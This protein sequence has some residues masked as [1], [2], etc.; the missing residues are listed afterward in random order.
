MGSFTNLS[1]T[2]CHSLSADSWIMSYYSCANYH[3]YQKNYSCASYHF[4]K[5]KLIHK[6][7]P[8]FFIGLDVASL[9]GDD[10]MNAHG[11]NLFQFVRNV[12]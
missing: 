7:K 12:S 3:F 4:T 10:V 11:L 5:K 9:G 1:Q 6:F 2:I 8:T